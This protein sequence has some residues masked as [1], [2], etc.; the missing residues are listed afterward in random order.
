MSH[1]TTLLLLG[2]LVILAPFL[3]LPYSWLMV[4]V[5]ILGICISALAVIL[6]ARTM[7]RA[8]MPSSEA[9]HEQ[10]AHAIAS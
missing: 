7:Q 4:M 10:E 9:V 2:I 1:E 8:P 3:G 5:P 6:R